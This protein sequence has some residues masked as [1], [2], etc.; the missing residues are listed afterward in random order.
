MKKLAFIFSIGIVLVF[1]IAAGPGRS[2]SGAPPSHSGAPDEKTCATGGCHDDNALNHGT[3]ELTATIK[4]SI[5]HYEAG[6]AYPIH[7]QIKD[8]K[9]TRFGFQIT[10]LGAQSHSTLGTFQI[11]DSVRTKIVTNAYELKDRS[12]VTY[13][14]NGTDAVKKGLGEWVVNW[15]APSSLS[16]DVVFY[17]SGVSA[18]DDMS[19][20]GD[21]VYTTSFKLNKE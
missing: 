20:K 18:N 2:S 10:A 5:A 13:T 15:V 7:I 14:F 11:I 1:A 3:A 9:K 21:H 6:K 19:D 8:K 12:Y 17:V 4:K 16:E